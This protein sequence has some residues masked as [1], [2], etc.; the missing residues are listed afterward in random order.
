MKWPRSRG[1]TALSRHRE[2]SPNLK[3]V[4]KPKAPGSGVPSITIPLKRFLIDVKLGTTAKVDL[5]IWADPKN[6]MESEKGVMLYFNV[7]RW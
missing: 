1:N 3:A 5:K 7:V 2:L 6:L 4:V